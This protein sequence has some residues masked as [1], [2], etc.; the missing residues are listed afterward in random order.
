M[1]TSNSML[2]R[3][4]ARPR[5]GRYAR[6]FGC[7]LDSLGPIAVILSLLLIVG[8]GENGPSDPDSVHGDPV[9]MTD[10]LGA[11][12]T[13]G[14]FVQTASVLGRTLTLDVSYSGGCADHSFR[15]YLSRLFQESDPVQTQAFLVHEGEDP[16]DGVLHETL[17]FDLNPLL[18]EYRLAYGRAGPVVIHLFDRD[19]GETGIELRFDP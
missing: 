15:L 14:Y 8:C 1:P 7:D 6:P 17:D 10:T 4:P 9:R 18:E 12:D 2:K 13:V 5:K 3:V 11:F 16:C 19:T